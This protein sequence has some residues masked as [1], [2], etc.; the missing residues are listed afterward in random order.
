MKSGEK[1]GKVGKSW[2]K[3]L[4]VGKIRNFYLFG[5]FYKMAFG[6]HFGLPK[7]TFNRISRHFRSICNFFFFQNG[8]QQPFWIPIFAKIDR[9]RPL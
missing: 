4:I 9:D 1:L 2:E 7:I 8:R 6:G 5:I 3:W